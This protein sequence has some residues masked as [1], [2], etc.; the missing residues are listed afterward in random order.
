MCLYV[1]ITLTASMSTEKKQK[2]LRIGV[3]RF[4]LNLSGIL[5][6]EPSSSDMSLFCVEDPISPGY[7][8]F[9]TRPWS[10]C[11]YHHECLF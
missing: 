4:F 3:D 7:P 11:T 6:Y 9:G 8:G 10:N 2:T 1:N 5:V